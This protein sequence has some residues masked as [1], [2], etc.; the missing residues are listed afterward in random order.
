MLLASGPKL[1]A[2]AR[3]GPLV[4]GGVAFLALPAPPELPHETGPT[5]PQSVGRFGSNA[6]G[7][8]AVAGNVWAWTEICVAWAAL[9]ASGETR[10]TTVD[11][12]VPPANLGFRL[13]VEIGPVDRPAGLR[14]MVRTLVGG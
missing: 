4:A 9:D 6:K 8:A 13:V 11:C 2:A 7:L 3:A 5:A 14:T 1:T 12:G 10:P